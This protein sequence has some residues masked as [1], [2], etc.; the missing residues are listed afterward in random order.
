M[1]SLQNACWKDNRLQ[2]NF[3]TFIHLSDS[4]W[5]RT[6]CVFSNRR[7]SS[8]YLGIPIPT[9]RMKLS[10]VSLCEIRFKSLENLEN[11]PNA[12]KNI[13]RRCVHL[14]LAVR[15]VDFSRIGVGRWDFR[16][17]SDSCAQKF[18][19]ERFSAQKCRSETAKTHRLR[20]I[21]ASTNPVLFSYFV[22]L[23]NREGR[24]N[25]KTRWHFAE[26]K[27]AETQQFA[28]FRSSLGCRRT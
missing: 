28:S 16:L 24:Q 2:Q 12:T 10:G 19:S 15:L 5:A 23:K 18:E 4:K 17:A 6:P 3:E 21:H 8:E 7:W 26:C 13:R 1:E 20:P 27:F 11:K 14:D 22:H 9:S 25:E